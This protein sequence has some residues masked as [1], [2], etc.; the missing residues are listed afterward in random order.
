MTEFTVNRPGRKPREQFADNGDVQATDYKRQS[1]AV[2]TSWLLRDAK[3]TEIRDFFRN[4]PLEQGMSQ[5]AS[6]RKNI[7]LAAEVLNQRIGEEASKEVCSTCGGP[8]KRKD[9]LWI[10]Q[11]VN[12]DPETG[13]LVPYRYC[14]VFCLRAHNRKALMP[15]GASPIAVDGTE[16]G[17]VR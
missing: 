15:E 6:A 11:G 17:D 14:D 10:Q 12:R 1:E 5:L 9:G 3:E 2:R 7:E 4:L 13:I 8:S 16:M